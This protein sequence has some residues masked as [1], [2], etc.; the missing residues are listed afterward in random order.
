M[1]KIRPRGVGEPATIAGRPLEGEHVPPPDPEQIADAAEVDDLAG[2]EAF[3]PRPEGDAEYAA[4]FAGGGRRGEPRPGGTSAASIGLV[5]AAVVLVAGLLSVVLGLADDG[6]DARTDDVATAESTTTT[7]SPAS[8][9]STVRS[10]TSTTAGATSTST[11]SGLTPG[12]TPTTVRPTVTTV[13]PSTTLP[14]ATTLAP[15]RALAVAVDVDPL[16]GTDVVA[17]Q[18]TEITVRLVDPDAEPGGNCLRVVVEGGL[19]DVV[20]ADN[21]C[22]TGCPAGSAASEPVGGTFEN[23]FNHTFAEAGT[24]HVVVTATSGRPGCGNRYADRV[25]D[26]RSSPVTVAAAD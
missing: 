11:T 20:L 24:Y 15:D 6:D 10:T 21:P 9:S 1:V 2:A 8:T 23:V 13:R 14:T 25:D 12:T 3:G 26:V 18:P 19:G 5:L 7:A 22:D 17:G 4:A 16:E